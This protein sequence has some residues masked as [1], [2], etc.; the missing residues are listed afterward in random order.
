MTVGSTLVRLR[1]AV[2]T[3]VRACTVQRRTPIGRAPLVHARAQIR[4]FTLHEPRDLLEA[5][6]SLATLLDA[7][8]MAGGID[9]VNELKLGSEVAHVVYLAGVP[10]LRDLTE[11][12]R[13]ITFGAAVSHAQIERDPRVAAALPELPAI[14]REL[15]N[16]RVRAAGTIG[17]N[18][19]AGNRGYDWLPIL[20]ALD[21]QLAFADAAARWR[22]I[23]MLVS[24]EGTWRLPRRLL[25]AVRIPLDGRP[26]LRFHRD[27]KPAISVALCVR[28]PAS[29]RCG[30]V[31]VGCMHAAPVA[32][33]LAFD[34]LT[35]L[36]LRIADRA[37]DGA[38][39]PQPRLEAIA[40]AL[41]ARAAALLPKP[42]DDGL[43]GG[44][45]RSAMARTLIPRLL[46]DVLEAR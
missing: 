29:G 11:D 18:L 39:T 32:R 42:H 21:A 38:A 16:V 44:G 1:R 37:L 35:P 5:A 20:L 15:G 45:Y 40:E 41:G 17:G 46:R 33:E 24:D 26:A 9:L 14:V 4:P 8:A 31:A 25:A 27:L 30:R 23:A 2:R 3:A 22:P 19:M 28:D 12:E 7:R 43:V 13:F 36:A 10:G 6:R 34:E